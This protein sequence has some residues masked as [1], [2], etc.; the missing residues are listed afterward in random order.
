MAARMTPAIKQRIAREWLIFLAAITLGLLITY[1]G[2]YL[3]KNT[4]WTSYYSGSEKPRWVVDER[5]SKDY[6]GRYTGVL[7][8]IAKPK[9][10]GDFFNDLWPIVHTYYSPRRYVWD[11]RAVKLWLC[12][13][14][15]YL[16][17]CFVRS[18]IW[19]VNTLRRP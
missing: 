7:Y 1:C 13:L 6:Y 15:P 3:G 18:I 10:P 4:T 8:T 2:F 19:S 14:G 17:F 12:I 16:G 9:N 11:E 5:Q